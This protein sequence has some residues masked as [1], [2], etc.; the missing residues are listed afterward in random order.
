LEDTI[1]LAESA[2]KGKPNLGQI[3]KNKVKESTGKV[4]VACCGPSD[5]NADLRSHISD[6]IDPEAV[7]RGI[8]KGVVY[9]VT[10][11]FEF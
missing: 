8:M 6:Q 4:V 7:R 5:L 2:I 3:L 9:L 11:D 10:E 1:V